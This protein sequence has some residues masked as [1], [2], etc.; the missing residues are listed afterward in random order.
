MIYSDTLFHSHDHTSLLLV[1]LSLVHPGFAGG[2]IRRRHPARSRRL[3]LLLSYV[4]RGS[5]WA[6]SS[7]FARPTLVPDDEG[8]RAVE[9]LLRLKLAGELGVGAGRRVCQQSPPSVGYEILKRTLCTHSSSAP[10][11]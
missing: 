9:V 10:P 6:F 5:R 3:L 8:L 11:P 4:L 2:S 1:L 7:A